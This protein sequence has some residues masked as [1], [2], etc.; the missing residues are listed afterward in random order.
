[1]VA[2]SYRGQ[3][4]NIRSDGH[5]DLGWNP[6]LGRGTN[7]EKLRR[8]RP[9]NPSTAHHALQDSRLGQAQHVARASNQPMLAQAAQYARER[10][11]GN[12]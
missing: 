5:P 11:R 7:P 8:L 12:A 9:P 1:M 2:G 4:T 6:R 3:K 10:F